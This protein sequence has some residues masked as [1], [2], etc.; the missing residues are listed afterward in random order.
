MKYSTRKRPPEVTAFPGNSTAQCREPTTPAQRKSLKKRPTGQQSA[1]QSPE[2]CPRVQCKQLFALGP[3]RRPKNTPASP[4]EGNRS[5]PFPKQPALVVP[6]LSLETD[7][8]SSV[9]Q[10]PTEHQRIT[11]PRYYPVTPSS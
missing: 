10:W 11:S 1:A 3:G 8:S 7:Q 2:R 5:I 9:S 4:V 6:V